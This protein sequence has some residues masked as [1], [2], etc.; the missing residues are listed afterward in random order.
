MIYL[1]TYVHLLTSPLKFFFLDSYY[2]FSSLIPFSILLG[3]LSVAPVLLLLLL[4]GFA[5]TLL[6]SFS[7]FLLCWSFQPSIL[8]ATRVYHESSS[9]SSPPFY[10]SYSYPSPSWTL[11]PFTCTLTYKHITNTQNT[12]NTRTI[13][14]HTPH[15]LCMNFHGNLLDDLTCTMIYHTYTHTPFVIALANCAN[16]MMGSSRSLFSSTSSSFSSTS[17]LL[18]PSIGSSRKTLHSHCIALMPLHFLPL[19]F[20][21]VTRFHLI[22]LRVFDDTQMCTVIEVDPKA[23]K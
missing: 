21:L 7:I 16:W 23:K 22:Y 13:H 15:I 14:T 2:F 12:Q 4:P 11:T 6:Q 1:L 18:A 5:L 3:L 10:S 9:S 17:H 8:I 20:S 19:S